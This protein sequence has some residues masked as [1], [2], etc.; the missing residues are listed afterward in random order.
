MEVSTAFF[1][2]YLIDWLLATVDE[3]TEK[4]TPEI[5]GVDIPKEGTDDDG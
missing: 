1:V 3:E 5:V 4:V 2:F